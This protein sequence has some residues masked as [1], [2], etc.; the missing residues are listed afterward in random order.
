MICALGVR[1][2]SRVDIDVR[3]PRGHPD[4]LEGEGNGAEESTAL[5]FIQLEPRYG[6]GKWHFEA[7]SSGEKAS[8]DLT[9]RDPVAPGYRTLEAN[10]HIVE[11][12]IVGLEPHQPFTMHFYEPREKYSPGTTPRATYVTSIEDRVHRDGTLTLKFDPAGA[13]EGCYVAKLEVDDKLV[14]DLYNT[15]SVFCPIIPEY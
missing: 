6:A 5:T 3:P 14:D 15:L 13:D 8:M 12:L 10:P 2:R 1:G 11:F 7:F 4:P 9:V